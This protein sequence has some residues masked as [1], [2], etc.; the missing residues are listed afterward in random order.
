[1]DALDAAPLGINVAVMLGH[2]PLRL[3]VM[4]EAA[5][6]RAARP[7]EIATM[8]RVAVRRWTPAPSGSRLRAVQGPCRLCGRPVPSRLA[9]FDEM[10]EIADAVGS[11]AMA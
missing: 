10:L 8:K 5:T 3:S 2:T 9:G 4:G 11:R 6:E 7:D 1:M